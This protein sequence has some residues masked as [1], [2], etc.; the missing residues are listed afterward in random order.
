KSVSIGL[1]ASISFSEKRFPL[2]PVAAA[3][4]VERGYSVRMQTGAAACIHYSDAAYSRMG[5]HIT[6]RDTTLRSDIVIH[7]PAINYADASRLKRGALLLTFF[8]P[9]LQDPRALRLLMQ[10]YINCIALDLIENSDSRK[11]FADILNEID[12]RAALAI[13]SS[14]LADSVHG[15]GILMGGVAGIVP[16]EVTVLGSGFDALAAART[17][18]GLGATVRMFDNDSYSLREADRMLGPAVITSAMHPRV[19]VSALRSADVVVACNN[20]GCPQ[21]SSEIVQEMKR[22]VIIFDLGAQGGNGGIFPSLPQ[23]DLALASPSDNSLDT[24]RRIC[25]VN[26]GS[27][28]PRTA[29]MALSNVFMTMLSDLLSCDGVANALKLNPGLR[30]GAYIFM[31]KPVNQRLA[32]MLNMRHVDISIMLQFS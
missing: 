27:A 1:P 30:K 3:V 15:K 13:A 10:K 19:L 25:Y 22:G 4:L 2:T 17:A 28:V 23:S 6:D 20:C 26:A 24:G 14:L 8:H 31:G 9:E 11:P 16:C 32:R 7:L 29:A 21:I 5:V 12:G 18:I